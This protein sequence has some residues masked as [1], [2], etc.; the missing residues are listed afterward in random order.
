MKSILTAQRTLAVV[1]CLILAGVMNAQTPPAKAPADKPE[2]EPQD[3]LLA[4]PGFE[5]D[6]LAQWL[7]FG[8]HWRLSSSDDAHAKSKSGLVNDVLP[9]VGEGW[10]GVFQEVPVDVKTT[11]FAS[12]FVRLVNVQASESFLEVQFL[13]ADG[14]VLSQF[15][16][17][18]LTENQPFSRLKLVALVPPKGAVKAGVRAVIYT[19][20]EAKRENTD[21]HIFDDFV[22][23]PGRPGDEKE[24]HKGQQDQH[25]TE[26]KHDV[27][28]KRESHH[29]KIE[30]SQSS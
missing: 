1:L 10:R 13:D 18:H 26:N 7:T 27:D 24:Q 14:K 4:N 25:K 28:G 30:P 3:N 29:R 11:Y 9:E 2:M 21:F 6:E 12:V 17:Q 15:Q 8:D 23:R 20:N 5:A 22:F 19:P 16:S